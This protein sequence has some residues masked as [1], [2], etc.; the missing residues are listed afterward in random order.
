MNLFQEAKQVLDKDGKVNALGPYGKG[1]LTGREVSTYFRRNKVK[2]AQIKKAVEVALDLGGAHS[3][4]TREIKNFYGDKILKS[5]E[6]QTALR[7][8]NESRQPGMHV[9]I[10]NEKFK[11]SP[12][13]A[14][15]GKKLAAFD[16]YIQFRGGKGDRITSPENKKDW[17]QAIKLVQQW[18]RK[19]KI[20]RDIN[21]VFSHPDQGSSAYKMSIRLSDQ[22]FKKSPNAVDELV[23][24]LS[25]LKTAEDHGGGWKEIE[26][27]KKMTSAQKKEFDKLYKKMDGGKEHQEIKR[28]VNNPIKADDAFHSLVM[29]KVM[30]EGKLDNSIIRKDFPNVWA[31]SAKDRKILAK[32][33]AKVDT[34]NYVKQKALYRKDI[35][36]FVDS[37]NEDAQEIARKS[38][39]MIRKTQAKQRILKMNIDIQKAKAALAKAREA[40]SPQVDSL[41]DKYQDLRKRR[42]SLEDSL[43]EGTWAIPDSKDKL[44]KLNRAMVRPIMIKTEK[45]LDKAAKMFAGVVGDDGV[46]DEWYKMFLDYED[47][48]KVSDARE[49]VVKFLKDWGVKV[50]NYKITHAPGS[51]VSGMD[52]DERSSAGINESEMQEG[53]FDKMMKRWKGKGKIKRKREKLVKVQESVFDAYRQMNEAAPIGSVGI[54]QDH[55]SDSNRDARVADWKKKKAGE[56]KVEALQKKLEFAR[57]QRQRHDDAA[58]EYREKAEKV[59]ERNPDDRAADGYDEKADRQEDM[60]MNQNDKVRDLKDQIRKAKGIKD[61]YSPKFT[62]VI[63]ES[64]MSDLLIDIQQGA[65]AKELA[66]DF[67]IPLAAAKNFLKDYYSSKP[68]PKK[69]VFEDSIDEMNTNMPEKVR[70]QLLT[71]YNK[72]MDLPYGS[73]AYKGI[74]KQIDKINQKYAVKREDNLM[75]SYRD[76]IVNEEVANITVDPRNKINSGQQQ[77]Y[78]GMEIAK[79]ARRMGLKSAVMHKHVRIKGAK[80]AV[81]DFLRI[82]IGKSRYGDPTEKDMSTPQIDKMLT[83]GLK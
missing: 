15:K 26:E 52:D 82:V 49:P 67:K 70:V 17:E 71:L 77:G 6:V 27:S 18:L 51:W 8:A 16:A 1:K 79:A 5:K 76:M 2:D 24:S 53:L 50:N 28:K 58:M 47:V 62:D 48:K 37:L 44:E 75:N 42:D 55:Q 19:H 38:A 43:H 40:G 30:G 63:A 45:D 13:K 72:A 3:I 68:R 69:K 74:K 81:N 36:G 65:T 21:K 35:K 64:R 11:V 54:R 29:K 9:E 57:N 12:P 56:S 83:K 61:S 66:R 34:K 7:Y 25:K 41:S 32:F 39:D 23:K 59:R 73:P 22:E 20:K 46:M 10:I 78:H 80:K 4:A 14:N 33:H 60:A 31:A